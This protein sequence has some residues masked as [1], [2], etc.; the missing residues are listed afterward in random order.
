MLLL[1]LI[2]L[3]Y[4]AMLLSTQYKFNRK[5]DMTKLDIITY[6]PTVQVKTVNIYGRKDTALP[7]F[8]G[9]CEEMKDHVFNV[10][11]DLAINAFY[12]IMRNMT[13][14]II[15]TLQQRKKCKELSG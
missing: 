4:Q 10:P 3:P 6:V 8:K 11:G 5:Q 7:I 13:E 14:P 12:I 9:K 1:C 2:C 15:L